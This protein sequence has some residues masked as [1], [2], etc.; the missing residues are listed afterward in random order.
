MGCQWDTVAMPTND[1]IRREN[2][3]LVIDQYYAGVARRLALALGKQATTLSRIYSSNPEH[4]RNV[5]N[6]M[7]RQI[8]QLHGLPEGWMDQV[9]GDFAAPDGEAVPDFQ[10]REAIATYDVDILLKAIEAA[11]AEL[12]N[13]E[14]RDLIAACADEL[15]N[16][17]SDPLPS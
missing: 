17:C 15:A 16:R 12:D 3:R 9:H 1:E 14:L 7:A 13:G 8:E 10:V 4:R 6:A 5:G 11:L 2:L